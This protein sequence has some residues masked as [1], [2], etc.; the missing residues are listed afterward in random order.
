G[1]RMQKT[2]R[3][4]DGRDSLYQPDTEMQERGEYQGRVMKTS[5]YTSAAMHP[6]RTGAIVV[7][8]GVVAGLLWRAYQ[9]NHGMAKVNGLPR[10]KTARSLKKAG[11]ALKHEGRQVAHLIPKAGHKARQAIERNLPRH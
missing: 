4:D 9:R 5:L 3:P 7:A 8:S 2:G 10:G 1:T 11:H 6:K